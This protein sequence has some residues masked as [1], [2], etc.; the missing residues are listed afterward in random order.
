MREAELKAEAILK[1]AR[2]QAK[3]M[4]EEAR[5]EA[6]RTFQQLREQVSG[7]ENE[8]RE[9]ERYRMNLISDLKLLSQDVVER[10]ERYARQTPSVDLSAGRQHTEPD[11]T[12]SPE[13]QAALNDANLGGPATSTPKDD[14]GQPAAQNFF[15]TIG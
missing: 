2:W 15:D 9:I 6:R 12:P 4:L 11:F 5:Q 7:L 1:E 14:E 8:V 10:A 3:T 13:L